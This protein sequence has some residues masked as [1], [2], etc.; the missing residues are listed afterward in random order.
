MGSYT[1]LGAL[2]VIKEGIG[3]EELAAFQADSFILSHMNHM[4]KGGGR[5]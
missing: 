5:R 4:N 1:V 2:I 3:I